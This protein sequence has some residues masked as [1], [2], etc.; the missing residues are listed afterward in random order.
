MQEMLSK[1]LEEI[2]K[3]QSIMN[4]TIMEMKCILEGTNNRKTEAKERIS[5]VKD[6]MVEANEAERKKEKKN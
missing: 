5:E 3:S 2:K 6:K 4:N 1:D